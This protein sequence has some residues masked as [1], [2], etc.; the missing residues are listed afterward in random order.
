M[1]FFGGRASGVPVKV[2]H[3]PANLFCEVS[4]QRYFVVK[5]TQKIVNFLEN[6]T[7]LQITITLAD[8]KRFQT[9]VAAISRSVRSSFSGPLRPFD[10][11]HL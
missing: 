9:G 3:I 4:F 5:C 7:A 2:R 1:R 10:I 6:L 8:G 11:S